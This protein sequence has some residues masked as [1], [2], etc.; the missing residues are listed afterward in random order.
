MG[1]EDFWFEHGRWRWQRATSVPEEEFADPPG[2]SSWERHRASG[3][4]PHA[5]YRETDSLGVTATLAGSCDRHVDAL[6]VFYFIGYYIQL[7][8]RFPGNL[9]GTA[10][11][12]GDPALL[13]ALAAISV[14]VRD[15]VGH[16]IA[17]LADEPASTELA[18]RFPDA[19]EQDEVRVGHGAHDFGPVIAE[20]LEGP[21]GSML[22]LAGT[23]SVALLDRKSAEVLR[24]VL[25]EHGFPQ[26]PPAS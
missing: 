11:Y 16:V 23:P 12:S 18:K 3:A 5:L 22:V 7:A 13:D 9:D 21:G 15:A 2:A 20:S 17:V 26:A 24:A 25:A 4:D 19:Y 8:A 14:E 6:C 1:A 10:P